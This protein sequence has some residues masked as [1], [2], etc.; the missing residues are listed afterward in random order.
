MEQALKPIQ[1]FDGEGSE[2]NYAFRNFC[3]FLLQNIHFR[4][5]VNLHYKMSIQRL[6]KILYKELQ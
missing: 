3:K 6:L 5:P 1:L 4:I 2:P